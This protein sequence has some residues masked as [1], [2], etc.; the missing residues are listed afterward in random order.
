MNI[1]ENTALLDAFVDGEL[2][3]DEMIQV[4]AHLDEC[5]ACQAYVDDALAIRAAFP[6]ED[7]VPLPADFTENV[8]KA[9]AKAPQSRP[10]KQPWGK[11]AAAAACLA[12]I[13]LVQ[14]GAL[15]STGSTDSASAY[16]TAAVMDV[17]AAE[18]APAER[19]MDSPSAGTESEETADNSAEAFTA[20]SDGSLETQKSKDTAAYTSGSGQSGI[21]VDLPSAS[22]DAAQ[23]NGASVTVGPFNQA[24]LPTVHVSA[25]D[26]GDLLDGHEPAET[27]N[28]GT[29]RY[30]LT[31]Q[32]YDDLVAELADRGVSLEE[33]DADSQQLWLEVTE[34]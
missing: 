20:T 21:Q 9:V 11:L 12:V 18:S 28:S 32:E 2:T 13:V 1:H 25:A 31:R 23:E 16:D 19:S 14:H 30:L 3:S 10:K 17:A 24:D 34:E 29:L 4:Q 26:I 15:G 5:P 8:M 27:E 7:T 22:E 6:T 33:P